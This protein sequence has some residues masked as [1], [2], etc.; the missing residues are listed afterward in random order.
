MNGNNM[1][2]M[3]L[4]ELSKVIAGELIG[5]DARFNAINIDSRTIKTGELFFA[6]VGEFFDGHNFLNDVQQKG[7]VAAVV[8]KKIDIDLPIIVVTNTRKALGDLAA[9]HHS[10]YAI[11]TLAITGSCGKTTTKTMLASIMSQVGKV[12]V[13]Q[14]SF[15]N[16][17][18]LPLTLLQQE[19]EHEFA[20]L[21]IGA[22]HFGEISHLTKIAKPDVAAVIN[23]GSAHLEGFG[24]LAGVS[25]AKGE[26]FQGLSTTGIAVINADDNYADYLHSLVKNH[27]IITFAEKN[28][29]DV[30]G[31]DI[32]V[33]E[34]GRPAFTLA[35]EQQMIDVALPVIGEHNV[36]NA[37]AAAAMAH[38]VNVPLPVIK[39]G[40]ESVKPV[41][42][43]LNLFKGKN[44]SHII[45][46]SY[47]AIPNAVHA[48]LN[49]L[50]RRAGERIFVFGGMAELGKHVE[51]EHILLGEKAHALGIEYLYAI[52]PHSKLT[53]DAFGIGGKYFTEKKDLIAAVLA[54]LNPNITVLVKGS[55]GAKME[56]VVAKLVE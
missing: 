17:I 16:D 42:K 20:V 41:V 37:L 8:N 25:R 6:I 34:H 7:A 43:R 13:N 36:M 29:A 23:I 10:K 51:Q 15:N 35:I 49:I 55:R 14:S 19:P 44:G 5:A 47:N 3:T 28:S 50:A 24:D 45:D 31:T 30:K 11:P 39:Q 9:Y 22:N 26:I 40:L 1:N 56:E 46:D 33:D 32:K 12:L 21:E 48:A 4:I 27:R 38:A 18:G 2:P 54:H 53:V 52:G